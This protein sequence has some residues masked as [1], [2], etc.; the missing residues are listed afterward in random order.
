MKIL[1]PID[2]IAPPEKVYPEPGHDIA[3]IR[4]YLP[5]TAARVWM[6]VFYIQRD[7]VEVEREGKKDSPP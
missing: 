7:S 3:R 4:Y 2:W 5:G 6:P 1:H